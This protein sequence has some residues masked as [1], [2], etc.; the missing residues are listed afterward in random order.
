MVERGEQLPAA[1]DD[2][3]DLCAVHRKIQG[4]DDEGL[5]SV[6]TAAAH[7][8]A[9]GWFA[10]ARAIGEL[11]RRA[12]Y[13]SA[14]VAEHAK[15]LGIGRS[16]AF[17]L[18]AIDRKILLPRLV[19]LGDAALFPI[20]EKRFYALACTLAAELHRSPLSILATAEQAR[21]KNRRF[22]TRALR[23]QLGVRSDP[24]NGFMRCLRSLGGMQ[25]KARQRFVLAVEDPAAVL[26]MAE[27]TAENA[28]LLA[29]EL[30]AQIGVD[31]E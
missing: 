3:L 24:V 1:I 4:L 22:S 5:V 28:R 26:R 11:Q 18:G 30:R 12:Q 23:A 19:E 2:L 25:R 13:K 20:R 10:Q 14:A 17:E 21:A 7:A 29:A 6:A 8:T 9:D 15:R 16:T 31:E 27:A